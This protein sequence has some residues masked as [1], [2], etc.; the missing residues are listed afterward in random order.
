MWKLSGL[1]RVVVGANDCEENMAEVKT[2]SIVPLNE[3]NYIWNLE[4][5]VSDGVDQERAVGH[6]KRD[7]S[8]PR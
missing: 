2:V 3:S 6:C 1:W 5:P 7:G 8:C 4:D